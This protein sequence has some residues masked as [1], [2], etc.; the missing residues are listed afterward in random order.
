VKRET[1][2][3]NE[4]GVPRED[5]RAIR[6][7]GDLGSGGWEKKRNAI[8]ITSAGEETL[9]SIIANSMG[10]AEVGLGETEGSPTAATE[11]SVLTIPRNPRLLICIHP[12]YGEVRVKCINNE[13]FMKNMALMARPPAPDSRVWT[14]DGRSPRWLGRW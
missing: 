2:L 1:D 7:S 3:A 9:R 11:M 8:F 13:N 12:D 10:I 14:L 6:Q 4:L 5:I